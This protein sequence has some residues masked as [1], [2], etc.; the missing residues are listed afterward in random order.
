MIYIAYIQLSFLSV[1]GR[2]CACV[3]RTLGG[4]ARFQISTQH[5]CD[6]YPIEE[7]KRRGVKTNKVIH[8]CVELDTAQIFIPFH[9]FGK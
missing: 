5:T 2:L 7:K 8:A 1:F 3:Y 4:V 6:K 9:P